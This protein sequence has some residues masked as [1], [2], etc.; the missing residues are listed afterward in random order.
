MWG[1]AGSRNVSHVRARRLRHNRHFTP[2]NP[3]WG[4]RPQCSDQRR[5]P[6]P[7]QKIWRLHALRLV[8]ESEC[9]HMFVSR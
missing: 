9:S 8:L 1:V 2:A 5:V 7:G 6:Q 4:V 3:W